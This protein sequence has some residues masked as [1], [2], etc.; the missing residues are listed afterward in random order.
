[1]D[2][3]QFETTPL[4][5]ARSI[6]PGLADSSVAALVDGVAWDLSRVLEASCKLELLKFDDPRG[7]EVR[8]YIHT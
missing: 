6:S 7:K 8:T 5:L 3:V 1:M 2:G 4:S